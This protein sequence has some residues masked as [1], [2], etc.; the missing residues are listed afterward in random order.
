MF[1]GGHAGPGPLGQLVAL[2]LGEYG[3][4]CEHGPAHR[5][6]RADAFRETAEVNTPVESGRRKCRLCQGQ[7]FGPER[8]P[9][10]CCSPLCRVRY[11][12]F[13]GTCAGL[14]DFFVV[15]GEVNHGKG[16]EII[17]NEEFVCLVQ[18]LV[19]SIINCVHPLHPLVFS[20]GFVIV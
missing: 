17:A 13:D 12:W 6:R 7:H 5:P 1:G 4:D 3:H 15:E 18:D 11:S 2:E 9:S 14:R 19:T 16:R 20:N 10:A 8:G